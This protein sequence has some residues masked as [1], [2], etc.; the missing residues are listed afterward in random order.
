MSEIKRPIFQPPNVYPT[1]DTII[2]L[3]VDTHKIFEAPNQEKVIESVT[4]DDNRGDGLGTDGPNYL[5]TIIKNNFVTWIGTVKEIEKYPNDQVLIYQ[6]SNNQ[7]VV[8]PN[9]SSGY[10]RTHVDGRA[11]NRVIDEPQEY[12]ISIWVLHEG[13][14]QGFIIDPKIQ[15][16]S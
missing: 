14:G 7:A 1:K 12:S 2:T 8:I 9:A 3:T 10:G 11:V 15:V 16:H 13:N 6:I 5:S 4:F